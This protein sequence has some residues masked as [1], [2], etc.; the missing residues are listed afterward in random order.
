MNVGS[1]TSQG[2]NNCKSFDGRSSAW[3]SPSQALYVA[4]LME[5]DVC[6]ET[7]SPT[8]LETDD[9]FYEDFHDHNLELLGFA[10]FGLMRQFQVPWQHPTLDK[11]YGEFDDGHL[12]GAVEWGTSL[13]PNNGVH[14]NREEVSQALSF[15][16]TQ[17]VVG[18]LRRTE[19]DLDSL[20]FTT[21]GHFGGFEG[22]REIELPLHG[23]HLWEQEVK[24]LWQDN[25]G[26]RE[27]AVTTIQLQPPDDTFSIH[28][29]ISWTEELQPPTVALTDLVDEGTVVSRSTVR[30]PSRVSKPM[31]FAAVDLPVHQGD[32]SIWKC[33]NRIIGGHEQIDTF[34]GQYH[35]LLLHTDDQV[36]LMQMNLAATSSTDRHNGRESQGDSSINE[37]S[38]YTSSYEESS[39]SDFDPERYGWD[40]ELPEGLVRVAC[41][42]RGPM[43]ASDPIL[44]IVSLRNE[45]DLHDHLATLYR[46]PAG[47]IKGIIHVAPEPTFAV[48][49]R[50]WPII[51]EQTQD[52]YDVLTQKLVVTQAEFYYSQAN[53]GDIA[54]QWRVVI[55][56]HMSSRAD[57]ISAIDALNYCEALADS[58][59]LV[60]HHGELWPQQGPNHIIRD[61]D[62]IRV[63]VPPIDED[64]IESTWIRVQDTYDAGRIVG[65]PPD[66]SGDEY[67]D[68]TPCSSVTGLQSSSH[69]TASDWE[70]GTH[71]C[72]GPYTLP[73]WPP[74]AAWS[75]LGSTAD[76][77]QNPI[78]DS[79]LHPGA[80][81]ES[82]PQ[83]LPDK[84]GVVQKSSGKFRL[85]L[86]D[87]LLPGTTSTREHVALP[88]TPQQLS[89]FFGAWH[90]TP[91]G[92]L[93]DIDPEIEIPGP[94]QHALRG[95]EVHDAAA[96]VL[97][98]FTDGSYD[99][100][101]GRMAWSF[102]AIYTNNDDYLEATKYY[103]HGFACGIVTT[104]PNSEDWRGAGKSNAYVA[105]MEALLQAHWWAFGKVQDANIHFHYDALS[106]GQ[107]T[108]GEWSYSYSH[109]LCTLT[110]VLSQS[111]TVCYPRQVFYH[112]VA[113]HTG[114]PWNELADV[115]ATSCRTGLLSPR[116]TP[117]FQWRPWLEG[118]YV[119]AVEHLPLV[120]QLLQ[121]SRDLPA[122]SCQGFHFAKVVDD[123]PTINSL[124]PMDLQHSSE[125]DQGGRFHGVH[126]KCCTY[127]VRTLQD[128]KTGPPV[129]YAEYLRTQMTLLGYHICALQETRAKV[130]GTIESTD[131]IRL[132]AAGTGGQEGCELWFSKQNQIGNQEVCTL[133]HLTVLHQEP[134]IMAVRLRLGK[135]FLVV[136][137]AHAPH[138]GHTESERA[139]WWNRFTIVIQ[140]ARHRGRLLV[141]GDFNAQLG[142]P[143]PD[144]VGDLLDDKTTSNGEHLIQLL[145]TTGMWLPCTYSYYHSGEQGTWLHPTGKRPIR[146]DYVAVDNRFAAYNV[147]SAVDQELDHPGQG[148][149][150]SASMLEFSFALKCGKKL[151]SRV[152]IDEMALADPSNKEKIED[153]IYSVAGVPWTRNVHDHYAS[154]AWQLYQELSTAF[155]QKRK[156]PRKHYISQA[157]WLCRASK[158]A[159][160]RAMR[161]ALKLGDAET[162]ELLRQQL[163]TATG[164][165]RYLLQ[166]DRKHHV[167]ALLAR[168]T[169]QSPANCLPNFEGL[170]LEQ[171]ARS[172]PTRHSQ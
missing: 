140:Q 71:D 72:T 89:S 115:L 143:C 47:F 144:V 45:D 15:G 155:P 148:E 104:D 129:G 32:E 117:T 119:M 113:A 164:Q 41:F 167:D 90:S 31:I 168:W 29:V 102:V 38:D 120:L 7:A 24:K 146:L 22:V 60:W 121:G 92:Q 23:I 109:Q 132:V 127:N 86:A 124:W 101:S 78:F 79:A 54:T 17:L 37:G 43:H 48:E 133:Q 21:Y 35:R 154:I 57:V 99:S 94:T 49:H 150:H 147:C 65:F 69:S 44:S 27:C 33:G 56:P 74:G 39:G 157:T 2:G 105:E 85:C 4:G 152:P 123:R 91:L 52:R 55:L 66:G 125:N 20:H 170:G 96:R 3:Y 138:S 82:Q 160:R 6:S 139:V 81:Q 18:I 46:M 87:H 130:S 171:L 103:F 116:A 53:A 161:S 106:A 10:S 83:Q 93:Y 118:H 169:M 142:E 9:P 77:T 36:S 156:R 12:P 8:S 137:T 145:T 80:F 62:L 163:R 149:D 158:L 30:L 135:E 122:G 88:I 108:K 64:M 107:A 172:T 114:D 19:P 111:L 50:A 61:G 84:E 70:S 162:A 110:R 26:H 58:R 76:F 14:L 153:I 97:H 1:I 34:F 16:E 13:H 73:Q 40:D 63:A 126:I 100:S 67:R 28:V 75:K 51:V 136:V 11:P 165:L 59:C 25:A 95:Q 151:R 112:H 141:M 98:L 131:F 166:E 159:M 42:K 128:P 134:S 68:L 5:Q